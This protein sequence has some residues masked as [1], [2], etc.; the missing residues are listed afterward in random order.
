MKNS[1]T[2]ESRIDGSGGLKRN[3]RDDDGKFA[4]ISVGFNSKYGKKESDKD[5]W[6]DVAE[7]LGLQDA[8][9]FVSCCKG[10]AAKSPEE[11]VRYMQSIV[12]H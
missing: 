6:F 7:T 10:F 1:Q 3:V 12:K 9:L 11:R 4:P 2:F 5:A 8:D